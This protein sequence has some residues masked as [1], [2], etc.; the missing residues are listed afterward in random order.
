MPSLLLH[1]SVFL[2]VPFPIAFFPLFGTVCAF[3]LAYGN[4]RGQ[5]NHAAPIGAFS[6]SRNSCV[7]GFWGEISSTVSKV[8]SD[9]K[10]LFKHKNG[11]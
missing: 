6:L 5:D 11:R 8:L 10:V 1:F 3:L 2:V 4:S 9:R 7:H